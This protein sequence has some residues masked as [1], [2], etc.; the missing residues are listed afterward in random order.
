MKIVESR[1]K[2]SSIKLAQGL[3][4]YIPRYDGAETS[5]LIEIIDS[6]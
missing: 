1:K 2:D 3:N 5:L 4:P 6:D